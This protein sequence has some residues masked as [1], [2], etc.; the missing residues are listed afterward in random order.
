V[1]E[2]EDV[3]VAL[4][5]ISEEVSVAGEKGEAVL[6]CGCDQDAVGWV[7]MDVAEQTG[8]L[9]EDLS[10]DGEELQAAVGVAS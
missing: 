8:G 4:A 3:E 2:F 7:A 5:A 9:D 6:A 1:S 10:C